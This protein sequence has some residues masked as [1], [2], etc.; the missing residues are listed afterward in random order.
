MRPLGNWNGGNLRLWANRNEGRG[1]AM[2]KKNE[3]LAW[4][5]S[6][7]AA[8]G[9]IEDCC[10]LFPRQVEPLHDLLNGG[11]CFEILEDDGDGHARAAEDPSTAYF[12]RYAFNRVAL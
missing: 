10:D 8:R 5:G 9:K 3:H 2:V 4:D 6:L 12:S 7:K 11:S 1:R